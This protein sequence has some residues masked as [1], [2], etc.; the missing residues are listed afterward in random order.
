MGNNPWWPFDNTLKGVILPGRN[1]RQE[2]PASALNEIYVFQLVTIRFIDWVI[3]AR[4]TALRN[5]FQIIFPGIHFI[6][7]GFF[8]SQ[9]QFLLT[10]FFFSVNKRNNFCDKIRN[11]NDN[12]PKNNA[13]I[14]SSWKK[15]YNRI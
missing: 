2:I 7:R 5:D 10:D 9:I 8:S 11:E 6:P 1:G 15:E 4:N 3:D 13:Q 12:S 14:C